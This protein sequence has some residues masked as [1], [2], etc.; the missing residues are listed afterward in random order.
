GRVTK[1]D[2]LNYLKSGRKAQPKLSRDVPSEQRKERKRPAA[3]EPAAKAISDDDGYDGRV[4]VLEMDRMRQIIAE[5]MVRSKA[6]SAH[7]T[8]FAEADVTNLVKFREANK[9]S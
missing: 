9:R 6:T 3:P 4:E 8:S 5:H 7:V 1:Q 2:I